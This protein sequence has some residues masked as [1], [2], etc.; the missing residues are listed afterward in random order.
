MARE[1]GSGLCK[2]LFPQSGTGDR[3]FGRGD[4]AYPRQYARPND[5]GR[6][7]AIPN[8]NYQ[9]ALEN[10][11]QQ[12]AEME[13]LLETAPDEEKRFVEEQLAAMREYRDDYARES[14]YNVTAEQIA[15]YRRRHSSWCPSAIL[16]LRI[17]FLY[18][19][20]RA[21]SDGCAFRRRTDPGVGYHRRNDGAGEW[22]LGFSFK[23]GEMH[24]IV[25]KL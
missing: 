20:D 19:A 9:A 17:R 21:I 12:I 10:Y 18:P 13:A 4:G 6:E 24:M 8:A 23:K 5:A 15:Q 16:A 3:V 25:D 7:R 22:R 11:D 1:P 2:S 14:Q